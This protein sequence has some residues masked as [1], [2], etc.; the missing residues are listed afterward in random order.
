MSQTETDLGSVRPGRLFVNVNRDEQTSINLITVI[1]GRCVVAARDSEANSAVAGGSLH[2]SF[3]FFDQGQG[4]PLGRVERKG[5]RARLLGVEDG[6]A[7][8]AIAGSEWKIFMVSSRHFVHNDTLL[9]TYDRESK[10]SRL[11]VAPR[12]TARCSGF[13]SPSVQA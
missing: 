12:A 5:Q 6:D 4:S 10:C 1:K 8:E 9:G 2:R 11:G 7:S 13:R 3:N